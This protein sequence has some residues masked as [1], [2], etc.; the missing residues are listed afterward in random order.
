MH[1]SGELVE[2]RLD[3]DTFTGSTRL[4][5]IGMV[6]DPRPR[7]ASASLDASDSTSACSS[8]HLPPLRASVRF[9]QVF[10]EPLSPPSRP[11]GVAPCSAPTVIVQ[12]FET[13]C[14]EQFRIDASFGSSVAVVTRSA[15]ADGGDEGATVAIAAASQVVLPSDSAVGA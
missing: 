14:L 6:V 13:Q 7:D 11:G 2:I 5:S 3:R 1:C 12:A 9:D 8:R 10:V 4:P 15:S